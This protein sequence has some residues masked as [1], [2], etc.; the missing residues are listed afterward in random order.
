MRF[1][2][3]QITIKRVGSP[4]DLRC[5]RALEHN[6]Q[7]VRTDELQ[8]AMQALS[9]LMHEKCSS[10]AS[11]IYRRTFF[12]QPTGQGEH[13]NWDLGEGKALWRGFYSC[14]LFRNG[15]HQLLMNIDGEHC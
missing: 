2:E 5:L 9:I 10:K 12:S 3:Y 6:D 4:I 13:G 15:A 14:L 1:T 8:S 11:F 7:Q